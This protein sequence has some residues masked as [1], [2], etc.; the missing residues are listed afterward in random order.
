M[1]EYVGNNDRGQSIVRASD[2]AE[3]FVVLPPG[4]TFERLTIIISQTTGSHF[5]SFPVSL[6]KWMGK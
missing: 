5:L 6:L 2:G 3:I 1:C 4:E